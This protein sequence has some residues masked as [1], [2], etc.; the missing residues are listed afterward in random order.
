MLK[1]NGFLENEDLPMKDT[2]IFDY[3][4]LATKLLKYAFTNNIYVYTCKGYL[5]NALGVIPANKRIADQ[6]LEAYE[7]LKLC[8]VVYSKEPT[9]GFHLVITN[10]EPDEYNDMYSVPN[11]LEIKHTSNEKCGMIATF[12]KWYVKEY[13]YNIRENQIKDTSINWIKRYLQWSWIKFLLP[14]AADE[15]KIN[16]V[17][18][19]KRTIQIIEKQTHVETSLQFILNAGKCHPIQLCGVTNL[20]NYAKPLVGNEI[21]FRNFR[22]IFNN[23]MIQWLHG[24]GDVDDELIKAWYYENDWQLNEAQKNILQTLIHSKYELLE[25]VNFPQNIRT[26]WDT[27]R[28]KDPIQNSRKR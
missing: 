16:V 8:G 13:K 28:D 18:L 14:L 6:F 10:N 26:I 22:Y 25:M 4:W 23:S 12:P 17:E 15:N 21:S 11:Q 2:N 20:V 5:T 19:V 27:N 3:S 7:K 1:E 24:N 9:E